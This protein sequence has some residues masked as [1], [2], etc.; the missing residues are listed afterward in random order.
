MKMHEPVHASNVFLKALEPLR[1]AL[2]LV[3]LG[4]FGVHP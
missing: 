4:D 2:S 1:V 3:S